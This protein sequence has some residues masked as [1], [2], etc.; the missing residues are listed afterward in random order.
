MTTSWRWLI[1][2]LLVAGWMV[3]P[4][5][6]QPGNAGIQTREL[7]PPPGMEGTSAR[8][9]TVDPRDKADKTTG[10]ARNASA[11]DPPRANGQPQKENQ[12]SATQPPASM[13]TELRQDEQRDGVA[14]TS[15]DTSITQDK[16]KTAATPPQRKQPVA[17]FWLVLPQDQTPR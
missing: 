13:T 7:P 11:T 9:G 17:A 6:G 8:P 4:A 5:Q 12:G 14:T 16:P 15:R 10:A 1:I 3:L 2:L